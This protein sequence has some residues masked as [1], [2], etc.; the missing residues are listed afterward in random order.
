MVISGRSRY[1][2][3]GYVAPAPQWP[4]QQSRAITP[5]TGSPLTRPPVV[6]AAWKYD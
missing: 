2:W 5:V 6:L 4:L 3:L 1:T